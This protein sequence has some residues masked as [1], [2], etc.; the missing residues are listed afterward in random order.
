MLEA[1]LPYSLDFI[2]ILYKEEENKKIL[3]QSLYKDYFDSYNFF[4][5]VKYYLE[6][7]KKDL[8]SKSRLVKVDSSFEFSFL[9]LSPYKLVSLP[10]YIEKENDIIANFNENE[11]VS[12]I[13]LFG[14]PITT[15]ALR[16]GMESITCYFRFNVTIIKFPTLLQRLLANKEVE[17]I[18]KLFVV[19]F[20]YKKGNEVF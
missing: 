16:E 18:E 20:E 10:I 6:E 1:F 3:K 7:F 17:S 5:E 4:E 19:R 9:M 12:M 15:K 13:N 11:F 14:K 8:S 2:T